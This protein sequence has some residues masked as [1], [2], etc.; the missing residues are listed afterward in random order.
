MTDYGHANFTGDLLHNGQALSTLYDPLGAA[1]SAVD[2]HE[3]A[4]NHALIA[5][6]LQPGAQIP[7]TDISNKPSVFPPQSHSHNYQPVDSDLTALAGLTSLGLISRDGSGS[8]S[9]VDPASFAEATHTHNYAPSSHSH[10][11]GQII[12]EPALIA[13]LDSLSAVGLIHQD[14]STNQ[15]SVK[16]LGAIGEQLLAASSQSSGRSILGLGSA[17]TF[18]SSSFASAIHTHDYAPSTHAHNVADLGL[19]LDVQNFLNQPNKASMRSVL[20][21]GSAALSDVVD[22]APASHAHNYA[23]TSHSHGSGDLNLDADVINFLSQ[24]TTGGMRGALG[25]GNLA[26]LNS[27]STNELGLDSDVESFLNQTTVSGMRSSLGL[28]SMAL[29]DTSNYVPNATV[30]AYRDRV[31]HSGTEG[32]I[33]QGTYNSYPRVYGY[34][35]NG[36]SLNYFINTDAKIVRAEWNSN[37]WFD[38]RVQASWIRV[39]P[40]TSDIRLKTNITYLDIENLSPEQSALSL[41][42]Q[43]EP[44]EFD[45]DQSKADGMF[46]GHVRVGLSAQDLYAVEPSLV[47]GSPQ[48]PEDRPMSL[49]TAALIPYLVLAVKELSVASGSSASNLRKFAR[50][51]SEPGDGL[52]LSILDKVL[53][54]S[55]SLRDGT[56]AGFKSAKQ[57]EDHWDNF[58]SAVFNA[59]QRGI[60]LGVHRLA[61]LLADAGQSLSPIDI[62]GSIQSGD[63]YDGWNTKCI[64]A[65]VHALSYNNIPILIA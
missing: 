26:I 7:W 25:L 43:I 59:D 47:H 10:S 5:T 16:P 40:D 34:A 50:Q 31:Y 65:N 18:S 56:K 14:S 23:P 21:L 48:D 57:L 6:A 55:W 41:F 36:N 3:S 44:I 20:E 45:W 15:Y 27:I 32:A 61:Q 17:A 4:F 37:G 8:F 9:T 33:F 64:D 12:G 22:F 28:G 51:F 60:V 1:S 53:E 29:Q 42:N 46:Q 58:R 2:S 39:N 35:D 30:Q 38:W 49:N 63:A 24:T 52:Y 54:A 62:S 11:W 13:N 19:A